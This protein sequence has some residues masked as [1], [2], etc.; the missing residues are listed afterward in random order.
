[1]GYS[2]Q[3]KDHLRSGTTTVARAWAVTRRDGITL[4]FTDHDL[5]LTFEDIVFRPDSGMSAKAVAQSTGLAVDNSEAFGALS[6]NAISETDILAGRYDGA[7]LRA[8][9]VNWAA[10]QERVLVFRGTLGEI[11]RASGAFTAELRGLTEALNVK[12]GRVFHSR[13]AAILGDGGCRFDLTAPGYATELEVETVEDGVRFGFATVPGFA[14]RWFEKGRLEVLTGAAAGLAGVIKADRVSGSGTRKI[15]LWQRIAGQV[16]VGDQLRLT[17]G[18]D[19]RSETCRVKF[20]NFLNFRGFPHIPGEDWLISYPVKAGN[21]DG[22]S[23]F[24]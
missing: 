8:W 15:E 17:A 20:D 5:G 11:I 6:G 3:F 13:C 23:L 2:T 4:G 10:P 9:L 24:R 7:Q 19:K 1:M 21:N 12:T 18:C 14:D 16:V 22:G